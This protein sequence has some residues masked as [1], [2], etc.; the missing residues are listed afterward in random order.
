[1]LPLLLAASMPAAAQ[2]GPIASA[3]AARF[4]ATA[5]REIA[6]APPIVP[7]LAPR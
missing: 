2:R 7:G 3:P 4:D 6:A 1:M 5:W